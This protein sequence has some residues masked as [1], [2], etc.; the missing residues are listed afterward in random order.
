M[1]R[2][3]ADD[4]ARTAVLVVVDGVPAALL[5]SPTCATRG[6]PRRSR[7]CVN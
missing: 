7:A 3:A 4:A 1:T 2:A 6:P 5:R